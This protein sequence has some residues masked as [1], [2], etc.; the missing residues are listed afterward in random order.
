VT[1]IE[2]LKTGRPMRRKSTVF[3]PP[4]LTLGHEKQF[5][6]DVPRWRHIDTGEAIGLHSWDYLADDWEVMP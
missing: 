5:G 3:A 2:A 6:Y 1:F 4:W